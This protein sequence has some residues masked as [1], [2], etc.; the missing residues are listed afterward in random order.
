MPYLSFQFTFFDNLALI[1]VGIKFGEMHA[2]ENFLEY[3][4][5]VKN[6]PSWMGDEIM[7]TI[8]D[9]WSLFLT[10]FFRKND[11]N[12]LRNIN[13]CERHITAC[14]QVINYS[15]ADSPEFTSLIIF[16]RGLNSLYFAKKNWSV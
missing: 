15:Y 12:M 4:N 1:K 14:N 3:F 2:N 16:Y 10:L 11:V 7:K 13:Q 6:C 5:Q 9:Y 8:E